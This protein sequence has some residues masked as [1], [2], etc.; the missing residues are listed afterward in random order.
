MGSDDS[1]FAKTVEEL[2]NAKNPLILTG[3]GISRESG[4]PVFRGKEGLW[5]S[6]RAEDLATL[7]A[8]QKNSELV[9]EWYNWRKKIVLANQPNRA[10][11]ALV[12]IQSLL[13]SLPVITQNVDGYHS[14]AGTKNLIEM[15]GNI[16]RTK[17]MDCSNVSWLRTHES[18]KPLCD[19]CRGLL[20]PDV[21]WFGE[22]LDHQVM[23]EIE[24]LMKKCDL[25][26]V[27]G[28][29][30]VVYPAAGFAGRVFGKGGSVIEINIEPSIDYAISIEGAAGEVLL[31]LLQLLESRLDSK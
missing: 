30:G 10:H 16:F 31:S 11:H 6:H 17:C 29:S 3:A 24:K 4:I 14:D 13:K 26:V 19:K 9:W 20:R 23:S 21:V 18:S 12:K 8:F 2:I 22:M 5:N 7:N 28:T 1:L 15:H 27:I 25:I